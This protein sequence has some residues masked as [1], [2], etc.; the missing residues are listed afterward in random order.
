MTRQSKFC[1]PN[2]DLASAVLLCWILTV[3]ALAGAST[4]LVKIESA[5]SSARMELEFSEDIHCT[6]HT[7]AEQELILQCDRA[8]D[9]PPTESIAEKS[10]GWIAWISNGYDTLLIHAARDV[11][12]NVSVAGPNRIFIVLTPAAAKP[13]PENSSSLPPVLLQSRLLAASGKPGAAAE[14]LQQGLVSKPRDGQLL[15]ELAQVELGARRWRY[16]AELY[17]RALLDQ[18]RNEDL[19]ASREKLLREHGPA[20]TYET[21]SRNVQDDRHEFLTSVSASWPISIPTKLS[22]KIDQNRFRS[23]A[24]PQQD[25]TLHTRN[26][27]EA[28]LQH[29]SYYG[30][31][32]RAALVSNGSRAG[33]AISYSKSDMYGM[34]QVETSYGIPFWD[35]LSS[36]TGNGTRDRITAGRTQQISTRF[37][38]GLNLSLDRYR[39]SDAVAARTYS[40]NGQLNYTIIRRYPLA[41][42]N[43]LFDIEKRADHLQSARFPLLNRAVHAIGGSISGPLGRKGEMTASSGMSFDLDG[44]RGPFVAARLSRRFSEPLSTEVWV[45]RRQNSVLTGR[46][47]T[48]LGIKVLFT[49]RAKDRPDG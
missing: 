9:L 42:I 36:L 48:S 13:L 34:T 39:M 10:D 25:T 40:A 28:S 12:F 8:L 22:L 5:K 43:Y 30:S 17:R 35:L 33:G 14:L 19:M 38:G 26:R 23:L 2:T 1:L 37:A 11:N 15:S 45:E 24:G 27:I 7:P 46:V 18:P 4:F 3:P 31:V 29:D 49:L 32:I 21:S 47:A 44:G 41:E 20:L 16:A 6:T